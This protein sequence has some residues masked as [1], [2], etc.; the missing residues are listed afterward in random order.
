[1]SAQAC[2]W[3]M[4]QRLRSPAEK[5]VLMLIA[6]FAD[7]CGYAPALGST[8]IATLAESAGLPG[9]EVQALV[10]GLLHA[11]VIGPAAMGWTMHLR[12]RLDKD[13]DLRAAS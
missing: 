7:P 5:L 6:D 13:F 8:E 12:L 11:G 1:M 2:A 3:A 4:R 10:A 9:G